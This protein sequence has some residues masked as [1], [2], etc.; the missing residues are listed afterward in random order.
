ME[1]YNGENQCWG[2][3]ELGRKLGI[4]AATTYRL[5]STL[6]RRAY[7]E[8][9][10]E[11]QKYHLGP[12]VV[13]WAA[14]YSMNNSVVDIAQRV[15]AKH[16]RNFP[17]NFYLG[18]MRDYQVI[19]IAVYKSRGPLKITTEPGTAVSLPSSA[20]GKVML[21]SN[22]NKFIKQFLAQHP[23]KPLTHLT[24]I[25]EKELFCQIE[26]VRKLGYA[27]N[28]GEIYP[29]IG[30]IAAPIKRA[31]GTVIAALSLGFPLHY[32]DTKKLKIEE[33]VGVVQTAA[34]EVSLMNHN[35]VIR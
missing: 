21:A 17:Y 25:S 2:I 5:V 34:N 18:V 9:N 3:R 19:Y 11:T 24:T 31:D 14:N 4:D 15:F 12:K 23:L 7:L 28:R 10:P 20:I 35:V 30:A 32:L 29:E 6:T 16:A 22:T 33:L 1:A 13:T 27:I 26:Q 8:K